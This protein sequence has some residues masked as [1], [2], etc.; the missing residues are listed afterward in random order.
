MREKADKVQDMVLISRVSNDNRL[1]SARMRA[2]AIQRQW[3]RGLSFDFENYSKWIEA[4]NEIANCVE[5]V[6]GGTE[7]FARWQ[8]E[9]GRGENT[10]SVG[11]EGATDGT[12]AASPDG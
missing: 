4:V 3:E 2:E 7:D 1:F 12:A 5:A 11:R 9:C 8:K 6:I 10:P